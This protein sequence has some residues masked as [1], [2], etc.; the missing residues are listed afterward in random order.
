[1]DK[2]LFHASHLPYKISS[3]EDKIRNTGGEVRHWRIKIIHR[4]D[5]ISL[6]PK[7]TVS[8]PCVVASYYWKAS[9]GETFL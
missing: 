1:M 2:Y 3:L 4:L 6:F 5:F 7:D 8:I 9:R